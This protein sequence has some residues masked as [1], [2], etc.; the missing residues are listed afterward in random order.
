MEKTHRIKIRRIYYTSVQSGEK[1]AEVRKDDR[2]Y[3]KGD[4]IQFEIIEPDGSSTMDTDVYRI[5]H[6]LHFPE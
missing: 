6:V 5:T 4:L 3:Q 2:D 1:K